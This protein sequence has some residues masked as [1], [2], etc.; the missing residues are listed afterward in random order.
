M[1]QRNMLHH[2]VLLI[3]VFIVFIY[4]SIK[5][6]DFF[7]VIMYIVYN[8]IYK[9]TKGVIMKYVEIKKDLFVVEQEVTFDN[10]VIKNEPINHMF[11]YDRSG[12]MYYHLDNLC[13]QLVLMLKKIPKGDTIS[14]GYFSGEGQYNFILKGFKITDDN[15]YSILEKTIMNNSTTIGCTCFSEILSETE[16]VIKDLSVFSD[17][18]SLHLLSDGYPVVSNYSKEIHDIFKAIDK[19]K[20]KIQTAMLIGFG[21]YYNKELMKKMTENLGGI[22]I[23]SSL[24]NEYSNTLEKFLSLTKSSSPK[25]AI[26]SYVENPQAIFSLSDEGVIL[27]NVEADGKIYVSPNKETTKVYYISN[28]KPECPECSVDDMITGLYGATFV[29]TQQCNTDLALEVM[30]KVGDKY[31]IDNITNAFTIDEYGASEALISDCMVN[32]KSRFKTGQDK[33]YLPPVDSFCVFDVLSKLMEDEKSYFFPYHE[34]FKYKKIGRSTKSKD[35]YPTFVADKNIKCPIT[36]LVW[37]ESRLNLSVKS[38]I[39]GKI[40]LNTYEEKSA[41]D[42]GFSDYYP[43]FVYRN[44][45]FIKD[46]IVNVETVYVNTS[47]DIYEFFKS[48]SVVVDDT[49]DENGIYGLQLLG[50]PAINRKMADGNTSGTALCK[51]L[52]REQELKGKLKSLKWFFE[53]EFPEDEISKSSPLSEDQ[54]KFLIANGIDLNQKG[55]FSPPMENASEVSDYYVAKTFDIKIKSLSS[56]PSVKKVNEKLESNKSLTL[57]ESIVNL[58]IDEY[59]NFKKHNAIKYRKVFLEEKI[60][61]YKKELSFVRSD[62]QR[63]KFSVVLGKKNF[64]EFQSREDNILDID[65]K[66]FSFVY[67]EETIKI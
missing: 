9:I 49:F 64:D 19:I 63:T 66:T 32:T 62:I 33:N 53:N 13:N 60:K 30:G 47:K 50:L 15:D 5:N 38:T 26:D 65:G 2:A 24:I 51:N 41:S 12:S 27:Y 1:W 54:Q 3:E 43:C 57:S 52:Y 6:V 59:L 55:L 22:L 31:I 39:K 14:I 34:N 67:G 18:F 23:H 36:T 44:Y 29:L 28:T 17:S 61:E 37:N 35:G 4:F 10:L 58:G 45:T 7:I 40:K 48:K 11:L 20:G 21:S 46:S 42:Y 8:Y 16:T 56:L 25:K